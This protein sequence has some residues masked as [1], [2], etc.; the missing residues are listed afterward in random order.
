[1]I[2][3]LKT[4]MYLSKHPDHLWPC[5]QPDIFEMW[6]I[7]NPDQEG[8]ICLKTMVMVWNPCPKHNIYCHK[9]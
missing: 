1:M 4:Y 6:K 3:T 5:H 9:Q 2:T 7:T 8:W